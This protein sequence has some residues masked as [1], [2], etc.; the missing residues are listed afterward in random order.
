MLALMDSYTN[1]GGNTELI[2]RLVHGTKDKVV[3]LELTESFH[4]SMVELGYH[5]A[6]LAI[7]SAITLKAN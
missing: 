4:D 5:S 2:V 6:L 7:S 1:L 3:P